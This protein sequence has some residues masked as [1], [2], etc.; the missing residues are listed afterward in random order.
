MRLT[1][2]SMMAA[3]LVSGFAMNAQAAIP[4]YCQGDTSKLSAVAKKTC[5]TS[6]KETKK[7]LPS[8]EKAKQKEELKKLGKTHEKT[9]EEANADA[10]VQR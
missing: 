3:L 10:R 4:D 1:K 5:A 2:I 8:V 7:P 9:I 6:A